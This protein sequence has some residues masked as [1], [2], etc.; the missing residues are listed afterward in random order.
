MKIDSIRRHKPPDPVSTKRGQAHDIVNVN[1]DSFGVE[2]GGAF[3][4]ETTTGGGESGSDAWRTRCGD[5]TTP[6]TSP[7]NIL[8]RR[9]VSS[10]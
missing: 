7:R 10:P 4:R 5:R 6:S 2:I 9:V 3:G 8:S 1:I